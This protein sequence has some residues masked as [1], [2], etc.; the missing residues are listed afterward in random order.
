MTELATRPGSADGADFE[1]HDIDYELVGTEPHSD[2]QLAHEAS[3]EAQV[4]K[5]SYANYWQEAAERSA[6]PREQSVMRTNQQRLKTA[7]KALF[8]DRATAQQACEWYLRLGSLSKLDGAEALLVYAGRLETGVRGK[9]SEAEQLLMQGS[10]LSEASI[11]NDRF[12]DADTDKQAQYEHEAIDNYQRIIT[13]AKK[14]PRY[15]AEARQAKVYISDITMRRAHQLALQTE[16]DPTNNE[17]GSEAKH[18]ASQAIT[19]LQ[20]TILEAQQEKITTRDPQRKQEI[21][22]ELVERAILLLLRRSSAKDTRS[23]ASSLPYQAF[24][25]QDYPLDGL[26]PNRLARRSFDV[27]HAYF[28]LIERDGEK[29]VGRLDVPVQAKNRIYKEGELP[30]GEQVKAYAPEVTPMGNYAGQVD[31][32]VR[33]VARAQGSR[34]AS[35]AGGMLQQMADALVARMMRVRAERLSP[36]P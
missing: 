13:M 2:R 9:Y 27:G 31:D 18:L 3:R 8:S 23:L 7:E 32:I 24:P 12:G 21:I 5:G 17:S 14:D 36:R 30:E 22:G 29:I 28:K 19:D 15:M 35:T 20:A 25:R 11:V 34:E 10:M 16:L 26:A 1:A 6:D 33:Q 4:R